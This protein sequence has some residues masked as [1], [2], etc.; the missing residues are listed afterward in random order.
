MERYCENYLRF[1][2]N[3]EEINNFIKKSESI[4]DGVMQYDFEIEKLLNMPNDEFSDPERKQQAIAK[5]GCK[6]IADWW[7]KNWG[8][9][10]ICVEASYNKSMH[11]FTFV[12]C[13]SPPDKAIVAISKQYQTL[14]F[15][16]EYKNFKY[17][18]EAMADFGRFVCQDGKIESE[19]YGKVKAVFCPACGQI[20]TYA[21]L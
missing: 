9:R 3:E 13:D 4:Y 7:S 15:T 19:E 1:E 12:T 14:K 5:Y 8:T 2:G 11:I 17:E 18:D 10:D 6:D 16:Y 21:K 20:M